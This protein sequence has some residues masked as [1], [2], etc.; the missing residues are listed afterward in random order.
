LA[1][2]EEK[3]ELETREAEKKGLEVL[4]FFMYH[5]FQTEFEQYV[6]GLAYLRGY[7]CDVREK[8][9]SIASIKLPIKQDLVKGAYWLKKS[10]ENG[11]LDA[12]RE[13]G[14]CYLNG[15]GV[16]K[17]VVQGFRLLCQCAES[18]DSESRTIIEVESGMSYEEFILKHT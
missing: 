9:F 3:I 17:D 7:I 11:S 4:N 12:K 14:L 8:N 18:G 2:C 16:E 13:L 5:K 6:T 1:L 15:L 10:A